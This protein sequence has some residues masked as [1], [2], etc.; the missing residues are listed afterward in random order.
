MKQN[1]AVELTE[2]GYVPD[3]LVRHG[4]RQLLR[5]RLNEIHASDISQMAEDQTRFIEQMNKSD[6]ALLPQK[7]N[8]QHYDCL[9]YT[10]DAADE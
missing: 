9:L 2:S 8:E 3:S 7:A 10:S 4:I 6:I 1:I 5:Q